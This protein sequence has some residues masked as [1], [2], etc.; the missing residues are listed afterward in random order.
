M[1]LVLLE[2]IILYLYCKPIPHPILS[3]KGSYTDK[4]P[5]ISAINTDTVVDYRVY[6]EGLR[7]KFKPHML[8]KYKLH[9]IDT[10][11]CLFCLTAST[12]IQVSR[13]GG[14]GE[15]LTPSQA[16]VGSLGGC[17]FWVVLGR[18]ALVSQWPITRLGRETERLLPGSGRPFTA[19]LHNLH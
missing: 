15:T 6:S 2:S 10:V 12:V 7:L 8:S 13:H 16:R 18:K 17:E 5:P 9:Q 1:F 14:S 11:F 19:K 4:S 3:L